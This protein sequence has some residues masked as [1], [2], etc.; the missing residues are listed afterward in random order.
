LVARRIT[1]DEEVVLPTK[2]LT[3]VWE[4]VLW[5]TA[6]PSLLARAQKDKMSC[7]GTVLTV[8][9]VLIL[10]FC[11]CVFSPRKFCAF[12]SNLTRGAGAGRNNNILL[13]FLTARGANNTLPL[14]LNNTSAQLNQA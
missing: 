3:N 11:G 2:L 6:G 9:S 13:A 1:E 4:N 10:F 7:L 12:A 8:G 5:S 14:W